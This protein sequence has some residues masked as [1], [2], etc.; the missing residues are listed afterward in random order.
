VDDFLL[1]LR[2]LHFRSLLKFNFL[3]EVFFDCHTDVPLCMPDTAFVIFFPC[4]ISIKSYFLM[5]YTLLDA[6]CLSQRI[7]LIHRT[8]TVNIL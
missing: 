3:I 6:I 1:F 7:A 8:C 5:F 4:F 2:V